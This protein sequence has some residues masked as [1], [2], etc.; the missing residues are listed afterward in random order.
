[1]TAIAELLARPASRPELMPP[2]GSAIERDT[3][4]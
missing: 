4:T 1:M 2:A 3:A